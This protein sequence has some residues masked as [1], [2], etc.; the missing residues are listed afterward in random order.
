MKIRVG[1]SRTN[2]ILSKLIRWFTDS[3][4]SHTYIRIYDDF[5]G[6]PIVLHADKHPGVC[7]I[8]GPLFDIENE[9]YTEYEIDSDLLD[10]SIKK[11]FALLGLKYD[12]W[13]LFS[14]AWVLTFKR[15]MEKK[16]ENPIE[17]PKK[18]ICVD[19]VLRILNGAKLTNLN[20]GN[21]TPQDLM[22][23][24]ESNYVDMGWKKV[25]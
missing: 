24:M 21:L 17:D 14:W 16:I 10:G 13:N 11:N 1:F 22:N 4:I 12:R 23:W 15:W 9:V 20:I 6:V 8:H 19:F 5:V 7:I 25:L 18:L 3:Q 2:T